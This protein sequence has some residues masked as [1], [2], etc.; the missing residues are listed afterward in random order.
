M[1]ELEN[2]NETLQEQIENLKEKT[3][4]WKYSDYE[5]I[6]KKMKV[7]KENSFKAK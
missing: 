1:K 3:I 7:W 2:K 5:D 4:Q 6:K